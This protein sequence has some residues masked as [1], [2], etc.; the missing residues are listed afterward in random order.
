M[1]KNNLKEAIIISTIIAGSVGEAYIPKLEDFSS[2]IVEDKL[3]EGSKFILKFKD[4]QNIVDITAEL[5]RLGLTISTAPLDK[6]L[7]NLSLP[8]SE[9]QDAQSMEQMIKNVF[10]EKIIE[11]VPVE[12]IYL[13]GND[14]DR[15]K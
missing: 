5:S 10:G 13:S 3:N 15:V 12:K 6:K 9:S 11:V 8:K 14:W 4:N 2:L 7:L 1:I